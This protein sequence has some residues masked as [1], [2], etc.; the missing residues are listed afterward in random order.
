MPEEE[1]EQR[2]GQTARENPADEVT[3]TRRR[4][5]LTKRNVLIALC[6]SLVTILLLVLLAVFLYRG[7]VGDNYIKAQFVSKMADIGIDFDADVFRVTVAPLRLELK[8]AT[9]NDRTSGEKLFFVRDAQLELTV[10]N[11]YAWQLSRDISVD[12]TDITGAEVWVKFDSEGRSNFSNLKLVEDEAGSRVNF[13][14][15]SL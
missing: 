3:I 15:E 1:V 5:F 11:L 14:Y 8:N 12:T 2:D 9:F 6:A 13:K 7:G 10:Q 4:S